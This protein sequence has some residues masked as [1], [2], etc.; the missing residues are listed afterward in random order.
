M[1]S[2]VSDIQKKLQQFEPAEMCFDPAT[3]T[4]DQERVLRKMIEAARWMDEIFWR[5]SSHD[6]LQWRNQLQASR[7]PHDRDMLRYVRIHYGPYDRLDEFHPFLGERSKPLGAGMY[8]ED[9]TREQFVEYVQQHPEERGQLENA[10][11]V[12][13]REEGKLLAVPYCREYQ[14]WLEPAAKALR[15]AAKYADT[16]SLK[17]YLLSRAE[18]LLNDNFFESDCHWIDLDDPTFDLVIGPY[19]V[20][21]D[22]LMSLKATYEGVVMVRDVAASEALRVYVARL[23]DLE[24]NLPI[25]EGWKQ[26]DRTLTSPMSVVDDIYRGGD[27]RAGYQAVAFVLPNDPQVRES[28]GSK[29]IFHKNFLAARVNK[30]I[31]PL[32]RELLVADQAALVTD[33]GFFNF[34]VMHELS[35]ALG[36]NYT[37]TTSEKIPINKALGPHYTGIEEGKADVV[38]LHSLNY[39]IDQGVISPQREREHY[40]SYLGGLLRTIRFGADEAHGR[41]SLI[42]FAFLRNEG[43]IQ[44]DSSSQRFAVNFSVIRGAIQKLA[45]VF[46][47]VE[48]EGNVAKAEELLVQF[49]TMPAELKQALDRCNHVPIEFEP[50][51]LL[52]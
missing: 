49:G 2:L 28:K 43:A 7:S 19:E 40:A 18:A 15:S 36:P 26:L 10:Y 50:V 8:P 17:R 44:Y 9:L 27:I 35:H 38:G 16:D 22:R 39:F 21:E 45:S 3:L 42:E 30:V 31:K 20:Y 4:E 48:A 5:Q 25:P 47:S 14:Q 34:V 33:E 41:A 51:F 1:T 52:N 6:A 46:M 13:K 12:V 29:K 11:T 23:L 37:L 32:A 24:K